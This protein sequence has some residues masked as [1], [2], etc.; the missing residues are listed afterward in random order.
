MGIIFASSK[1]ENAKVKVAG[2]TID[3]LSLLIAISK[4]LSEK[5][6]KENGVSTEEAE[7]VILDII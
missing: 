4:T 1:R 2:R 5:I 6:S 3:I 7:K